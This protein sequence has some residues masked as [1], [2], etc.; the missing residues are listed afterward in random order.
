MARRIPDNPPPLPPPLTPPLT[1]I[2]KPLPL[3]PRPPNKDK[4]DAKKNVSLT[5]DDRVN[6]LSLLTQLF[7]FCRSPPL[8]SVPYLPFSRPRSCPLARV[9]VCLYSA[10]TSIFI[11]PLLF[12]LLPF[13][14]SFYPSRMT[15]PYI[16]HTS[17]SS[18]FRFLPP[19]GYFIP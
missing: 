9:Y 11:K 17:I 7:L 18:S 10:T 3:A 5:R 12:S 15:P 14:L 19:S 6:L 1:L 8:P 16:C 2:P 13:Y 4:W